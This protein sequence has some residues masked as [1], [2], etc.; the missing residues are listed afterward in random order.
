MTDLPKAAFGTALVDVTRWMLAHRWW[1][2]GCNQHGQ[3]TTSRRKA[4]T[5]GNTHAAN[6]RALP[7]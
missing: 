1:C 5:E 3:F 6:C 7:R 2:H 4:S